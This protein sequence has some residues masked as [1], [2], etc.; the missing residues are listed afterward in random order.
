MDEK[1]KKSTVDPKIKNGFLVFSASLIS[2]SGDIYEISRKIP[3]DADISMFFDG[4][5]AREIINHT[6]EG[7]KSP[8]LQWNYCVS[9]DECD[10]I[11]ESFNR[12]LYGEP[13]KVE[14]ESGPSLTKKIPKL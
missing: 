2:H 7:L 11:V 9:P 14:E 13:K 12:V 8:N 3:L 10:A 1:F 4:V 6:I 5:S